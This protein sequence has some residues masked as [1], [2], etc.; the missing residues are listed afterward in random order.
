MNHDSPQVLIGEHPQHLS[1]DTRIA[2]LS[3]LIPWQ[4]GARLDA[5]A[6]GPREAA[7]EQIPRVLSNIAG[8]HQTAIRSAVRRPLAA[9][10]LLARRWRRFRPMVL[11]RTCTTR[12]DARA[13]RAVARPRPFSP[14]ARA[15]TPPPPFPG[16]RACPRR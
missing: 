12:S 13:V 1:L 2:H 3:Q 6:S 11:G 5:S 8:F 10:P 7:R 4:L 16:R 14:R 9:P 15:V